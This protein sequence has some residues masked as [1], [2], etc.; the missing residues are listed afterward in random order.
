VPL[1]H[2]GLRFISALSGSYLGQL[3]LSD[4][5]LGVQK[6]AGTLSPCNITGCSGAPRWRGQW[7]N[8]LDFGG[9]ASISATAYYTSGYSDISTD[10]GG[11]IGDCIASAAN[12]SM[13]ATF[14]DNSPIRCHIKGTWDVD[15]TAQ[16]KILHSLTIYGNVLNVLGTKPPYDPNAAYGIYQFNPS[17]GDRGFIGRYFRIGAR[18]DLDAAAP[19]PAPYVAPPAPPPPAAAPTQTCPDGTVILAT[20]ACPVAPPPPPP[21]PAAKPERGQ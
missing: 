21:P 7:Q 17:W 16:V 4:P 6:Y 3:T 5:N 12:G 19:A 9:R 14:Y 2:N 1:N 13:S 10:T 11:I 15:L 20:A 18:L 8:T